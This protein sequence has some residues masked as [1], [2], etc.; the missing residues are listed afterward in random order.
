MNKKFYKNILILFALFSIIALTSITIARAEE[1]DNTYMVIENS[2]I[3]LRESPVNGNDW[4]YGIYNGISGCCHKQWL[5]KYN[6]TITENGF[7][8][9]MEYIGTFKIT[10][11]RKV[12]SKLI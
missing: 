8:N 12:Y 4:Y 6:N 2:G 7:S 9:N 11:N 1:I 3:R 10:G 5:E